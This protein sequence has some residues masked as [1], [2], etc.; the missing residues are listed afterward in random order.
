MLKLEVAFIEFLKR[1]DYFYELDQDDEYDVITC[2]NSLNDKYLAFKFINGDLCQ[3]LTYS[4]TDDCWKGFDDETTLLYT[5]LIIKELHRYDNLHRAMLRRCELLVRSM[6]CLW[7][8][9][10]LPS[11]VR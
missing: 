3:I 2:S 4:S 8:M 9:D 7:I 6:N 5:S 10:K 11:T 1:H